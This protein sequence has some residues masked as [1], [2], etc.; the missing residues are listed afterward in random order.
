MQHIVGIDIGSV[1]LSVVE[2][3]EQGAVINSLYSFHQGAIADTLRSMLGAID[4][5]GISGVAMTES[6]PDILENVPRY[7]TQIAMIAAVKK[8]HEKAGSILFVG[9]ENFGL[10][11]FNK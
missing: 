6:G 10:I 1:A 5:E 9:G 2:M 7:D 11:T 4:I 8:Y 3:D